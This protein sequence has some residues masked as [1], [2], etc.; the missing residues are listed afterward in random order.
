MKK[1]DIKK[2]PEYFDRYINL[3]DDVSYLDALQTSLN[4]LE[5]APVDK[6]KASR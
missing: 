6:W 2:M 4:E 3:T 5:T 1:S